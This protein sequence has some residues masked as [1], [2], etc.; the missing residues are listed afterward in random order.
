MN[1]T[2]TTMSALAACAIL[3]SPE[4][5]LAQKVFK[6]AE[7]GVAVAVVEVIRNADNTELHLQTMAALKDVCWYPV[8]AYSPYLIADGHRYVFNDGDHLVGCP[9]RM[10]YAKGDIMVLRFE[11][12]P[13]S[14]HE[15]SLVEGKGGEDQMRNPAAHKG[16]RF[17]NFLHI[18]LD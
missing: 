18:K 17:W 5:A 7:N 13:A 6:R 10:N 4:P 11:P 2:N 9:S 14:A 1:L 8:G 16:Q 12:L 3:L 15:F